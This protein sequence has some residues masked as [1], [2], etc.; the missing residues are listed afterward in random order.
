MPWAVGRYSIKSYSQNNVLQ[1]IK[2][3]ESNGVDYV[4]L[5]FP[6][7]TWGN[8]RKDPG[9]Y[10]QIPRKKGDFLWKQIAGAK[11]GGAESLYVAMFDEIDEGTAIFKCTNNPP[12]GAS[13]FLT[14]EG[15]P[16]DHY[17]HL[18]G[19]IN[20]YIEKGALPKDIPKR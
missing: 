1:D 12:V 11:S 8:L 17:L 18:C 20:R 15:L 13:N 3:T 2:W 5:V 19:L 14:Y 7:F 16:S 9:L 4:P 6:G 10:N